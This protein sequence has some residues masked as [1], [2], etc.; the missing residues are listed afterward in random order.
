MR[1]LETMLCRNFECLH[2]LLFRPLVRCNKGEVAFN[3]IQDVDTDISP[4]N[5]D[6]DDAAVGLCHFESVV[7]GIGGA[8]GDNGSLNLLQ[9]LR[10]SRV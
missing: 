3:H 2:Q 8:R 7:V 10:V 1:R 9:S 6:S 4:R 5:P